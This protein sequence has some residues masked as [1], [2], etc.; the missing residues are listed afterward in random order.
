[1]GV[2]RATLPPG[3][4]KLSAALEGRLVGP[5]V[6]A[7]ILAGKT[8][9][10]DVSLLLARTLTVSAK[11]PFGV[12]MPAKVTVLCVGGPCPFNSETYR[13]HLLLDSPGGGPAVVGFIPVTGQLALT[14]PPAEYDVV[15][16]RGP[17]YSIWPDT[18]PTIGFRVDLRT[19][20][21]AANAVLAQVVD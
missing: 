8:T 9:T 2:G 7:T 13:R 21:A 19:A 18:W 17:E 5:E 16:S 3:D 14:L 4:Y 12:G 10:A 15:V 20:D 6:S 1:S 11:D